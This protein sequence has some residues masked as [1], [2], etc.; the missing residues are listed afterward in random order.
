MGTQY[1]HY[2]RASNR[3]ITDSTMSQQIDDA[4]KNILIDRLFLDYTPEEVDVTAPLED[5]GVDSFL[6][7]E[8]IVGIEEQFGVR[9]EPSDFNTDVFATL[10]SVR[11][12]IIRKQA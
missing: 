1:P 8:M 12:W 5:Y 6:L 2:R 4:L 3:P 7:Q 10:T 11:A 9:F